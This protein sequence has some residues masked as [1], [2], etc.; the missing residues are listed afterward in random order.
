[1]MG[2][3]RKITGAQNH[4]GW[5]GPLE[6]IYAKPCAQV[7]TPKRIWWVEWQGK[8][9]YRRENSTGKVLDSGYQP[10]LWQSEISKQ[11]F[12]DA[13]LRY[14]NPILLQSTLLIIFKLTE[15]FRKWLILPK[16]ARSTLQLQN[17]TVISFHV[18][19]TKVPAG[20]GGFY[21]LIVILFSFTVTYSEIWSSFQLHT[22]LPFSGQTWSLKS[23]VL[24]QQLP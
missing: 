7:G 16:W 20:A 15:D 6:V 1:M 11:Q 19:T 9:S 24:W 22:V 5:K 17:Q 4:R 12:L 13:H 18:Q 10:A 8:V 3:R 23:Y 21:H 2:E 14:L